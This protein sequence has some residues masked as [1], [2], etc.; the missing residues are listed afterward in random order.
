MFTFTTKA[1]E[2]GKT[3]RRNGF[4]KNNKVKRGNCFNRENI[5]LTI[6]HY[7]IKSEI[8]AKLLI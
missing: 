8:M 5:V 4:R 3:V 1:F 7:N 6:L 2:L